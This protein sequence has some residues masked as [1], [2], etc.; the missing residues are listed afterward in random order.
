LK[1]INN[2]EEIAYLEQLLL[3]NNLEK[4]TKDLYKPNIFE[5]TGLVSQEIRHSNFLS[6]LFDPFESHG[7]GDLFLK[8]FLAHVVAKR[9]DM[10]ISAVDILLNDFSDINVRREWRHIDLVIEWVSKNKRYVCAIENKIRQKDGD[11]QLETYKGV[12]EEEYPKKSETIG[13]RILLY[14]TPLGD[15]PLD[16]D[17]P[18]DWISISYAEDIIPVL[19]NIIDNSKEVIKRDVLTIFE[20]YIAL[21]RRNFVEDK[22]ITEL[23]NL[24]YRSHKKAIDLILKNKKTEINVAFQ[25][26]MDNRY[27]KDEYEVLTERDSRIIYIP[28][29]FAAVLPELEKPWA[30]KKYPILFFLDIKQ[31]ENDEFKIHSIACVGPFENSDKRESMVINLN[32]VLKNKEKKMTEKYTRV[33]SSSS[34][35]HNNEFLN[36]KDFLKSQI[37][38]VTNTLDDNLSA[39]INS[40]KQIDFN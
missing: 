24:I 4:L 14:L 19:L 23:C 12:I 37:E 26:Y 36:D 16:S 34:K 9:Q 25:E 21:L 2:S 3:D 20:H 6:Y 40:L 33:Y 28:K 18:K 8:K 35:W 1:P 15:D 17:A 31:N 38:I 27:G 13:G 5:A 11:K 29:I 30:G 22:R 32:Q 10:D 39:A 7:I